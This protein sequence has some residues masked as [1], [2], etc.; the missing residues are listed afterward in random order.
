[1][2][3]EIIISTITA[4]ITFAFGWSVLTKRDKGEIKHMLLFCVI[5]SQ[6]LWIA[7]ILLTLMFFDFDRL[8][9]IFS[10]L[11]FATGFLIAI[12]F[13]VLSRQFYPH[14]NA[15][16]YRSL[17]GGAVL[18]VLLSFTPLIL[19]SVY[20][21]DGFLFSNFG[22]LQPVYT[23][24]LTVL[25]LYSFWVLYMAYRDSQDVN[26]R[27][28]LKYIIGGG[29]ISMVLSIFSNL[30]IPLFGIEIRSLGPLFMLIFIAA[31]FYAIT[32]HRFL[33]LN[34][35]LVD[36]TL[37]LALA[38]IPFV[39]FYVAYELNTFLWGS[40]YA[41]PAFVLGIV[42]SL[43]FIYVFLR[44]QSFF[45]SFADKHVRHKYVQIKNYVKEF[46]K[47]ILGDVEIQAILARTKSLFDSKLK[48]ERYK[49]LKRTETHLHGL[50][51]RDGKAI[52]LF[53]IQLVEQY[54]RSTGKEYLDVTELRDEKVDLYTYLMKKEIELIIPLNSYHYLV[55]FS[56][57][58][59]KVF[60]SFDIETFLTIGQI[61]NI[62]L[63]RSALYEQ[64]KNFNEI[65]QQR[66]DQ[67]TL[68]L[69]RQKEKLQEKYQFERDMMGIM[70]HELR[71]PMTV[72]K[73]MTELIIA[74]ASQEQVD[75]KYIQEKVQKIYASI[76]KEAD[77]IQTMLSTA[78][79]DNKKIN[80]QIS[81]MNLHEVIEYSVAAF[82]KDAEEKGL[83]LVYEEPAF[84]VPVIESDPQRVQEIVNNLVSNAVKYTNSGGITVQMELKPGEII[85]H[86]TDTGIGIPQK[87]LNNLGRK[88]YR[89]HQHLDDKKQIV[90]AGG[91]GLG[92]Y[93]VKGLLEALGGRLDV[94]SQYGNGSVF[95]AV[96]PLKHTFSQ[97]TFRAKQI[98][99]NDM[100]E[101]LGL[102]THRA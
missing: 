86:I 52:D 10:R 67:A 64:Q 65:L 26:L 97:R 72:A 21:K 11:S 35:A 20:I 83:Y 42:E 58:D 61:L 13:F 4:L 77:L 51:S 88:F 17:L 54:L 91:T 50:L 81:E 29:L 71:T 38:L 84:P 22:I 90:R 48:V 59:K 82:K 45:N 85:V 95:S 12:F 80:L 92:L 60:S 36:I 9:L 40:I 98:D 93:V 31:T 69:R 32:R 8:N 27:E 41:L 55:L 66:I 101:Q 39:T 63:E 79:I 33:K 25:F 96:F 73:G 5:I 6:F 2:E 44:L 87:E 19:D 56:K 43:A 3:T 23:I 89:I 102:N 49:I 7:S 24:Y 34:I 94:S 78:H 57:P 75:P 100:F 15:V 68:L 46:D 14:K 30:F 74:K 28:Q 16:V 70:G 1:M 53:V 76:M 18:W 37:F 99:P 62:A 47:K